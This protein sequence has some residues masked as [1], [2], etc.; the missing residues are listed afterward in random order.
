MAD[1]RKGGGLREGRSEREEGERETTS[2]RGS[3]VGLEE[4]EGV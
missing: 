1:G 4:R 2:V 3:Q